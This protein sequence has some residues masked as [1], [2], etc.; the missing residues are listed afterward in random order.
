MNK[1][2]HIG[3]EGFRRLNKVNV[4]M[5][6]MMVMIGANGVGKTSFMDAL[7]LLA[8]SARGTLN[9]RLNDMG[10]VAD[11]MTRDSMEDIVLSA[12][13]DV[14]GYQ[15][16]EYSLKVEPQGQGYAISEELLTQAR[17]NY[18]QPFKHI[19]SEY[20]NIHF[21]DPDSRG[22]VR[23]DWEHDPQE[24]S[25]SQ[26]PKM[27]REPEDL[28]RTLSSAT[29]YHAL[30]VGRLAPVKLPQ[31]LRPATHPGENGE[32]LA[33]FLYNLRETNRDQFEAVED[34]LRVAFP[35][36]ESLGFPIVA[37]GMISVTW[38][39]KAFREPIYMH[40]LSEG[41][42][43]FL[44]LTSLLQSPRLSTITMIDEPE[45]SLHPELL[46]ILADLMREAS[47]RTQLIVATHSDRFVRFLEPEEVLVMD[48]SEEGWASMTWADT[49][50]LEQWLADYGLDEVWRM[51][52]I[53]GRS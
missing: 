50:D 51:G 34:S 31:Q 33:P 4:D 32:N 5:R 24:S 6:P 7:S 52:R 53:G 44:W 39:E 8:A 20:G 26:V 15:P 10:G 28:R 43:R 45:V 35:G 42:L 25:L 37:A 27:F 9:Q 13:M 46:A 1:I 19:E 11:V 48:I 30:D 36:F 12:A 49:L 38:K 47:D 23:P 22:L 29:Q 41:T 21:Y 2:R 18:W 17:P 3:V 16:L 40:Q 14:P